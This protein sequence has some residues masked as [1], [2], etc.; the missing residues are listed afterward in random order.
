MRNGELDDLIDACLDGRLS[1][2]EAA[3]LSELIE[4]S[5]DARARYWE[6]ASV[7]GLLEQA[8]QQASLK[9]AIGQ[10]SPAPAGFARFLQ[11]RALPPAAAETAIG[12]LGRLAGLGPCGGSLCQRTGTGDR[13]RVF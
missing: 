5:A 8:L 12:M 9:A 4:G 11:W 10:S 1:E 6:M 3:K 2:A 13:G 7:H